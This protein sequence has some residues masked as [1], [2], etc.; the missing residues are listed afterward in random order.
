MA[1]IG[2]LNQ[3]KL[4]NSA[5]ILKALFYRKIIAVLRALI[6]TNPLTVA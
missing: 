5:V 1:F 6:A 4:L 3:H 2:L